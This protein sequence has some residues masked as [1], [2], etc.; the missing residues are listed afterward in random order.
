MTGECF[1]AY[2]LGVVAILRHSEDSNNNAVSKCG[3]LSVCVGCSQLCSVLYFVFFSN[4]SEKVRSWGHSGA[5]KTTPLSL[6]I[7]S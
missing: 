5:G 3:L 4:P 7:E 2:G 6:M 1:S